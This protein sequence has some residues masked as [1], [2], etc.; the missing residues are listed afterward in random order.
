MTSPKPS[1]TARYAT[2]AENPPAD[3]VTKAPLRLV[4]FALR[5]MPKRTGKVGEVKAALQGHVEPAYKWKSWW[6]RV[7]PMLDDAEGFKRGKT[8]IT[9]LATDIWEVPAYPLPPKDRK[10]APSAPTRSKSPAQSEML[11]WQRWFEGKRDDIPSKNGRP[12]TAAYAAID[13]CPAAAVKPALYRIVQAA[14]DLLA[15]DKPPKG[16]AEGWAKLLSQAA[17]RGRNQYDCYSDVALPTHLAGLM[18]RLAA[19]ADF[20]AATGQWLGEAGALPDGEP[21]IWRSRFAAG[22]W[23]QMPRS[24][25]DIRNWFDR[26]FAQTASD[27][28]T[29]ITSE[30]ALAAFA[31]GGSP[32]APAGIDGL[33]ALLSAEGKAALL[34]NLIVRSAAG[35]ADR[36]NAL[37]YIVH[38][39]SELPHAQQISISVLAAVLLPDAPARLTEHAAQKIAQAID[40]PDG[41]AD[42]T[43]NALLAESRQRI[44]A[45]HENWQSDIHALK[46]EQESRQH[47]YETRLAERDDLIKRLRAEIAAGREESRMDIRQGMLTVISETILSLRQKQHDPAK[48]LQLVN[49]RLGLAFHAGGA[50]EFGSIGETVGYN[51]VR[52]QTEGSITPGDPAHIVLPGAMIKGKLTGDRIL[53][54]ARVA[55]P[56]EDGQC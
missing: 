5:E 7:G 12:V 30:I 46:E 54:K 13:E 29:A 43:W 48:A 16:A 39:Q 6:D 28:R 3:W 47:S 10:P 25:H 14:E 20:P 35:R 32:I 1:P 34:R 56:T 31:G 51:P 49:D 18:V 17:A 45:R 38:S 37:D 24:R 41:A 11:E 50:E 2:P 22:I 52:H 26:A 4:A 21:E 44:A 27:I 36:R 53:V 42:L 55:A 40:D 15:S 33:L 8:G 9:L 23:D 19:A